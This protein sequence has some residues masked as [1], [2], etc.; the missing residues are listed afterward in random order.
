VFVKPLLFVISQR[1]LLTQK[2]YGCIPLKNG[3]YH[4]RIDI[5]I[6]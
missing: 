5:T 4:Q 1:L 3:Q 6:W 2:P